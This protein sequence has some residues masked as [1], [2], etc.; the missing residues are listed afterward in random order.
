M[1]LEKL[2]FRFLSYIKFYWHAQSNL[3]IHSPFV[4][5]LSSEIKK[6]W[7]HKE[8]MTYIYR[9][10]LAG[11]RSKFNYTREDTDMVTTV[12]KRYRQTSISSRYG[13]ILTALARHL[14]VHSFIELGTSMG[15]S[16]AYI[17]SAASIQKGISIDAN[18]QA[19]N[20][21]KNLFDTFFS[22][23][24][25]QFI[26]GRFDQIL[27]SLIE[28][29]EI[30]DL[31]FIDGDHQYA[32]TIYYF[33]LLQ[34]LVSENAVIVFDDIRWSADMYRAWSEIHIKS[35]F[36]YTLDFGRIGI[37]IRRNNHSP[38]QHFYLNL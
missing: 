34:S 1:L 2:R 19:I 17:A 24:S 22:N 7:S 35:D 9:E 5:S 11:D 12:S 21:A 20:I 36:N 25:V 10:R 30:F 37:L 26:Q 15:V 27:P 14:H 31:V 8:T 6:E 13:Q 18:S 3:Y 28:K 29:G 33:E 4:F 16:T 38:K 23:H 32:S